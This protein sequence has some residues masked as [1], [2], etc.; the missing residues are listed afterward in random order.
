MFNAPPQPVSSWLQTHA[1][2]TSRRVLTNT[3]PATFL[4]TRNEWY[5]YVPVPVPVPVLV[6]TLVHILQWFP[7]WNLSKSK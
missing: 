5:T 3:V 2:L 6:L 1:N 7:G 4:W